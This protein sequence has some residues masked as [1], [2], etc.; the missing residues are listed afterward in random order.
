MANDLS[1]ERWARIHALLQEA[2]ELSPAARRDYSS[3]EKKAMS[4]GLPLS[5]KAKSSF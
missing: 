3:P 1:D 4:C 2:I 5:R